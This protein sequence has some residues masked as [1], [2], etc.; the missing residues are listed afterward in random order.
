MPAT[1]T[2]SSDCLMARGLDILLGV[3][4]FRPPVLRP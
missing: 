3:P 1:A 4:F 2:S